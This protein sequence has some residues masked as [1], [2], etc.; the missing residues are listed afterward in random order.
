MPLLQYAGDL[1]A[2]TLAVTSLPR[3]E[4]PSSDEPR[5]ARKLAELAEAAARHGIRPMVEFMVFRGIATIED[6]ARVVRLAGHENLGICV[7]A[8]DL[9]RSGGTPQSVSRIDPALIACVQL[10]DAPAAAPSDEEI[11]RE[12]RFDRRYPGEGE[13]PLRALLSAIPPDV[14]LSVEVPSRAHA[15]WSV[16]RRAQK[17]A[18]AVRTLIASPTRDNK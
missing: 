7:D 5:T 13:L 15:E 12:A 10:C 11:P 14:P 17:A 18:T 9:E 1:G 4:Y 2:R 3:A 8:L 6:A 16:A